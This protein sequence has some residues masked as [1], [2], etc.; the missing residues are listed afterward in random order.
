MLSIYKYKVKRYEDYIDAPIVK[1]L[2]V[3]WQERE[4]AFCIWA[5]VNDELPDSKYSVRMIETGERIDEA[6]LDGYQYIGTVNKNF[7]V[8]HFFAAKINPETLKVDNGLS[9]E[10]KKVVDSVISDILMTPVTWDQVFDLF[11][12]KGE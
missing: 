5:L 2:S 8:A 4:K 9:E 6:T 1:W 3:D 7:Y 12:V 10:Q 11:G